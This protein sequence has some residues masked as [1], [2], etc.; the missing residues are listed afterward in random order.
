MY[1]SFHKLHCSANSFE[2]FPLKLCVK[3][4]KASFRSFTWL[5]V[6]E[7]RN[8][9]QIHERRVFFSSFIFRFNCFFLRA[10]WKKCSKLLIV[11][12][13]QTKTTMRWHLTPVRMALIQKKRN[14][15]C[16]WEWG[17]KGMLMHCWWEFKLVQPLWK[18]VWSFLKKFKIKLLYDP[19]IPCLSIYPKRTK[20]LIWK[21]TC[22]PMFI[23]A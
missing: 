7:S 8:F 23:A 4:Y 19:T 14:N 13:M 21:V 18:T 9:S 22:T 6:Y 2:N 17:E 3:G 10:S 16:W 5:T 15:K 1:K 11:R 12:E 20:T